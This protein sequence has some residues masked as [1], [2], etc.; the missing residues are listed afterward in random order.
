MWYPKIPQVEQLDTVDPDVRT[1][2]IRRRDLGIH[3][4]VWRVFTVA[5]GWITGILIV[6]W[7]EPLL[8]ESPSLFLT[9][10]WTGFI[11]TFARL[12]WATDASS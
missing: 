10:G 1:T 11:F 2:D 12:R 9:V 4:G 6:D 8:G 3:D 7:L 5:T